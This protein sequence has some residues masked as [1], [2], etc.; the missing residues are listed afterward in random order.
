MFVLLFL[1]SEYFRDV[2]LARR[3]LRLK[4]PV[5]EIPKRVELKR[6][7]NAYVGPPKKKEYFI[8]KKKRSTII[9]QCNSKN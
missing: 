1:G 6:C 3:T 7:L 2:P 9:K 8:A 4:Q 5:A